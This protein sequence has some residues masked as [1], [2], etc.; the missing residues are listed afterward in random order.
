LLAV[1][2]EL[3]NMKQHEVR[4][5]APKTPGTQELDT[6]WV[7][8][9]KFDTDS[10][11]LKYKARLCVR[12]FC[13]I[14]GIAYNETFAST[15]RLATLRLLLGIAAVEDFE[16]QQM[17]VRC[18][19]LN[20]VPK[21]E[22]FIKVLDGLG[23]ELPAG[24][25][26]KLQRLLYGLK[27]SPRC[28]Y[29][30]L[31]DFFSS[32]DFHPTVVDPCLFQHTSPQEHCFVFVHVDDLVIVGPDVQFLKDKISQRFEMEDLGACQY[33]LGMRVTRNRAARTLTLSQDWYSQEILDEFGLLDCKSSSV[34]LPT[35]V[36]SMPVK[37]N[38]PNASFNFHR[39]VGLLQYLVQCTRPDLAYAVSYHQGRF[40]GTR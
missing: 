8:K 31:K 34:L 26:L 25:G 14:K 6:I 22:L 21:Q 16:I 30:E 33:I 19:F 28:W 24:H 12:G 11:L 37:A 27:Q 10:E 13:Q 20:G 17:D 38:P 3:G 5:V 32:I 15:G 36:L 9:R 1:E 18:A 7:F 4:V 39:G 35:N 23:V 2:V 29:K 40:H